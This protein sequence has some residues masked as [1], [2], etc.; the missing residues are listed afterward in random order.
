VAT[1]GEVEVDAP[2][3]SN[4]PGGPVGGDEG[5]AGTPGKENISIAGGNCGATVQGPDFSAA[6]EDEEGMGSAGAGESAGNS[7]TSAVTLP[8]EAAIDRKSASFSASAGGDEG[9]LGEPGTDLG[10]GAVG[11]ENI[12]RG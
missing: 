9:R 11:N 6:R 4:P 8:S 3:R 5:I 7:G 10:M 12:S 1:A 2:A